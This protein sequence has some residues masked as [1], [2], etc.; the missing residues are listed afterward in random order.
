MN[1]A[2]FVTTHRMEPSQSETMLK[3]HILLLLD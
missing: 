1:R 3:V 2:A